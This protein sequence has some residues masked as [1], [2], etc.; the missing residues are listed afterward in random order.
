V[1][2]AEGRPTK[3]PPKRPLPAYET[4]VGPEGDLRVDLSAPKEPA[5]AAVAP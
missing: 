5:P 2:D 1:F 3:G 4:V